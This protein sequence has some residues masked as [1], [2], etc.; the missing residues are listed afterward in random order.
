MSDFQQRLN[1][2]Y[3]KRNQIP[4]DRYSLHNP[5][6]RYMVEVREANVLSILGEIGF[7]NLADKKVLDIGCGS[8]GELKNF[9]QYGASPEKLSGIDMLKDRVVAARATLPLCEVVEGNGASSLPWAD[10]TFNLALQFTV[11]TSILEPDVKE[12]L[13]KEVLR[14]IKPG[15][16]LIW[17]DFQFD[18]PANKD[19]KGV[20]MPEILGL[21]PGCRVKMKRIT[22]APPITRT[23]AP[24]STRLCS[25]L[26]RLVVLNTHYIGYIQKP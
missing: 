3:E 5:A 23:I 22:L 4:A 26:E 25:L 18:N 12:S 19:V 11:F 13:A 21:F 8:G 15:G 9:I 16:F 2:A 17:Y 7:A 10:S 24:L 20:K 14:V 6:T 1:V